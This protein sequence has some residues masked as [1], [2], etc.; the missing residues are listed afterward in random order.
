MIALVLG[1]ARFLGDLCNGL[2]RGLITPSAVADWDVGLALAEADE[3]AAAIVVGPPLGWSMAS[4]VE[5]LRRVTSAPILV[6]TDPLDVQARVAVLRAGADDCIMTPFHHDELLARVLAAGRRVGVTPSAILTF[7]D[8]ILDLSV[9]SIRVGAG[10]PQWWRPKERQVLERLMLS[11]AAMCTKRRMF[12]AL[13]GERD[14]GGPGNRVLDV[15]ISRVRQRLR[16]CASSVSI[17]TAW[18]AGWWLEIKNQ[19]GVA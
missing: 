12:H 6:V 13:Y 1:E 16:E 17:R 4:A 10:S 8:V 14:D 15:F 9:G 11:G 3:Y 5:G 7:G 18:S 19:E 2:R